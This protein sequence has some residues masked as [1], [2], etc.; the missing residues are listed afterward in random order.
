VTEPPLPR[1]FVA[2]LRVPAEP[3][4]VGLARAE[5][6][7]LAERAGFTSARCADVALAVGEVCANVV[8]HAYRD[9]PRGTFVIEISG[10]PGSLDVRVADEGCGLAPRG[11]SPGAGYGLPLVAAIASALELRTRRA[12]GLQ[13]LRTPKVIATSVPPLSR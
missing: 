10:R 11:D 1:P 3:G 8:V 5:A 4:E 13:R 9:R 2:V 6:R 12:D 7:R